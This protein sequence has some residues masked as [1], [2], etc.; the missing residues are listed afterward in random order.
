MKKGLLLNMFFRF[1]FFALFFSPFFQAYSQ[2]PTTLCGVLPATTRITT[3]YDG[4]NIA[5]V[6]KGSQG[7]VDWV[8]DDGVSI[9]ELCKESGNVYG[10]DP[11]PTPNPTAPNNATGIYLQISSGD[12][13][14]VPKN[15]N[16]HQY[17]NCCLWSFNC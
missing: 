7:E 6:T 1:V 2:P 9:W 8:S 15:K 16:K 12:I 13:V 5:Y 17:Y 10:T 4:R 11:I 3:L 14:T